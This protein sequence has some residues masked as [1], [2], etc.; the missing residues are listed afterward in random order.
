MKATQ[1]PSPSTP[2]SDTERSKC[3]KTDA[4][5]RH[6][7]RSTHGDKEVALPGNEGNAQEGESRFVFPAGHMS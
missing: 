5:S 3:D 7:V 1:S 2:G 4:A 6:F